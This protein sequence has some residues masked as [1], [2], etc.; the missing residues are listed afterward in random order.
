MG[1]SGVLG[2]LLGAF[3][4]EPLPGLGHVRRFLGDDAGDLAQVLGRLPQ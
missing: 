4:R 2:A 3:L 1:T